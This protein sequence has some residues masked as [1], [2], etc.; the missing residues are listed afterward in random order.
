MQQ[1]R[2]AKRR[3]AE[4]DSPIFAGFAVKIGTVPV[5]GYVGFSQML[6]RFVYFF[7]GKQCRGID[8]PYE[9]GGKA[10]PINEMDRSLVSPPAGLR[11]FLEKAAT[12]DLDRNH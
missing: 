9:C 10:K 5:N 4:G 2:K 3:G 6:G 12:P 1:K 7:S 11:A 8:L